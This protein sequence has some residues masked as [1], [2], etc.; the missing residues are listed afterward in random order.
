MIS[1]EDI[2]RVRQAINIVDLVSETVVLKQRGQE[3]W[4]CCPVHNE[5]TP[6]FKVNAATGL[7]HCFGA[8][9]TGGDAISYIRKRD[10]L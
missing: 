7:W 9:Q 5:K 3:F 10:N 6:S 8:C 2:Q 4:G 1:D